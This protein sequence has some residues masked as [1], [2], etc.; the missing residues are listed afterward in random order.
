[1]K[2]KNKRLCSPI[3]VTKIVIICLS[4]NFFLLILIIIAKR[5]ANLFF[6]CDYLQ[7]F[8]FFSKNK[9]FFDVYIKDVHLQFLL[10]QQKNAELSILNI[11]RFLWTFLES[12]A[13]EQN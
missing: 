12:L 8:I 7:S 3:Y 11:S 10:I 1:M 13:S 9:L 2:L 6:R 5:V 4:Y